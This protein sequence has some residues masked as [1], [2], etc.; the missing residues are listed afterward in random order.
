MT[1]QTKWMLKDAAG[2]LLLGA[3]AWLL[4]VLMFSM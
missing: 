4:A 1:M 3:I 2:A